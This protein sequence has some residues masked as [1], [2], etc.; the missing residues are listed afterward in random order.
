MVVPVSVLK[1][2]GAEAGEYQ[3]DF[4]SVSAVEDATAG[5]KLC[6]TAAGIEQAHNV[7]IRWRMD[8]R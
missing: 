6:P 7:G 1:G 8:P 2:K 4:T 5:R 3:G